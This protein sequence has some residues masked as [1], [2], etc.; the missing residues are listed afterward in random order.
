MREGHDSG[1]PVRGLAQKVAVTR[2][3]LKRGRCGGRG[4]LYALNRQGIAEQGR[5]GP[6]RVGKEG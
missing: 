6:G 4:R 3:H 5:A 1:L 2:A